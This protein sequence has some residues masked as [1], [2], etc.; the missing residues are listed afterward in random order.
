M[1]SSL[2]CSAWNHHVNH[3]VTTTLE[4]STQKLKSALSFPSYKFI[5]MFPCF[6]RVFSKVCNTEFMQNTVPWL[7]I[8]RHTGLNK[9]KQAFF[10]SILTAGLLR[11]F[12]K[13]H[14]GHILSQHT[15]PRA[16]PRA[17]QN[18]PLPMDFSFC[19]LVPIKRSLLLCL[20]RKY[21]VYQVISQNLLHNV[22]E[23]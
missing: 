20:I 17:Q 19:L 11:A 6:K 23:P 22:R 1:D 12:N 10:F 3:Y 2:L 21:R 14:E 16:W 18:L 5:R 15:E 4:W 8:Q 9:V 13:S 7:I